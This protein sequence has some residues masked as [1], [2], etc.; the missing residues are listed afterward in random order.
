M[1][2]RPI[3]FSG[4][5]VRAILDG[6]KTQT[7]RIVKPQPEHLQVHEYKGSR[8]Y[9]GANRR[10]CWKQ[11]VAS[12]CW[13]IGFEQELAELCPIAKPGDRLWVRE[14]WCQKFKEDE[15]GWVYNSE[16]NL[17]SSCVHYRADGYEVRAIDGD[18]FQR[19]NKDGGEASPWKPSIHMPRWASRI[20]LEVVSARV[21]RL[22]EISH[23]D[24][25]A[26]GIEPNQ[27]GYYTCHNGAKYMDFQEYQ[28][29]WESINGQGS[30]DDNPYVWVIEF[31][32]IQP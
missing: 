10:W 24:V 22:N 21:E 13:S 16:D 14:S 6:R 15:S 7:R 1:K 18:G 12:D 26:E 8:I 32:V 17:D 28:E 5:M 2:E 31:T 20:L 23:K 25:V 11:L 29:L 19:W 4:P 9:D 30:W 27:P 3:L